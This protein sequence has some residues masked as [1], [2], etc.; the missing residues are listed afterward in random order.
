M[1]GDSKHSLGICILN[2]QGKIA[3]ELKGVALNVLM[4]INFYSKRYLVFYIVE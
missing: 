3:W 4:I 2:I 1:R